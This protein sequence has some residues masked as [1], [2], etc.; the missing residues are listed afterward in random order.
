[1]DKRNHQSINKGAL[2][3]HE[4]IIKT[5][6]LIIGSGLSGLS[7]GWKLSKA[8]RVLILTKKSK[9]NSNSANA[10]GGIAVVLSGDEKKIEKHISD[11]IKAGD[12]LCDENIVRMIVNHG[13]KCVKELIDMG[14]PFTRTEDGTFD[15]GKEGG[16][17]QRIVIHAGDITGNE[18]QKTMID[19]VEEC[20]NLQIVEH[21]IAVNL[22]VKDKQCLGIY[23]LNTETGNIASIQSRYT[24]LATGGAGKVYVY[25]SNPDIATG[26]G[27]AMAARAGAT[28]TNMEFFQFHPT[29]LYHPYAKSFLI[30]EA[31]R[32]E[33]AIL[34]NEQGERFMEQ[35]DDRMELAPRDVVS[36]SIDKEM[37][38]HGLDC[39]YLDISF[40]PKKFIKKRF[41]NIHARC[42]EYNIDMTREPIPVVP[43]A[44]YTCGGILANLDGTTTIKGLHAIGETSC[45]GFHGAN[46]LASN[47][48]LECVVMADFTSKYIKKEM[49]SNPRALTDFKPWDVGKALPS[50]EGVVV[51][52]DWDEIRSVMWNYVGIVR[53]IRSLQ[54][55]KARIDLISREIR[56]YYWDYLI[57]ADLVELR[58]IAVVADLI[59]QSAMQRK[60]SRGT[61]FIVDYPEKAGKA[62]MTKLVIQAQT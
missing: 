33:G 39:V 23:A 59:I 12:G 7:L 34:L 13:G 56:E 36:R 1:M 35:Y 32:G 54:R 61:H 3:V 18:V 58:N 29:C 10:Q 37:K 53:S 11:T 14:V 57:T 42:L 40:K 22:V 16:H 62:S 45:T 26:D 27:I 15:Y 21:M 44:H 31:L 50:K 8:G 43:A 49:D 38:I 30:S 41:P 17:S 47:S 48:L 9:E 60:E 25:T 4:G 5:D 52:H 6:F 28:I 46:R 51:K 24:I 19:F 55:A 20:P 2:T